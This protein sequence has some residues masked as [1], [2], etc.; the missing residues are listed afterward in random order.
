MRNMPPLAAQW[1]PM[2]AL[3]HR[4]AM[5]RWREAGVQ[6]RRRSPTLYAKIFAVLLTWATVPVEGEAENIDDTYSD[7]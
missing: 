2:R 3:Q 1:V 4:E 5:K 7:C 6:L